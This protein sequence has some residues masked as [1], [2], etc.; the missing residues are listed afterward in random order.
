MPR[1]SRVIVSRQPD[2]LVMQLRSH[3]VRH[4]WIS[5]ELCP[6]RFGGCLQ[7]VFNRFLWFERHDFLS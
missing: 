2:N 6:A 7:Q 4:L 5:A 1:S 3:R